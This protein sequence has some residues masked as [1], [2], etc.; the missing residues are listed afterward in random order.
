[1]SFISD[2]FGGGKEAPQPQ[3]VP[4]SPQVDPNAE[5]DRI[6]AEQA[7]LAESKANGRR[8]TIVAGMKIAE[9]EQAGTGLLAAKKRAASRT[10]GG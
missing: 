5:R 2:I 4:L 1:M 7:A 3:A 9:D 6:A 10:L 8:Q